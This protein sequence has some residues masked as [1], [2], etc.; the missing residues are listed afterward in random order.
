M[1]KI[2]FAIIMVMCLVMFTGCAEAETKETEKVV[3]TEQETVVIETET[4]QSTEMDSFFDDAKEYDE[5]E[6]PDSKITLSSKVPV[7][8][9]SNK[10]NILSNS[11]SSCW[12]EVGYACREDFESYI[13]KCKDLGYTE[14]T[15]ESNGIVPIYFADNGEGIGVQVSYNTIDKF[16][17]IQ[18]TPDPDDWGYWKDK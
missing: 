3:T 12:I 9:W 14:N 5:F 8:D 1:S 7:P 17:S 4:E 15:Y 11:E 10:G 6:W 18:V 2:K 16:I 13:E